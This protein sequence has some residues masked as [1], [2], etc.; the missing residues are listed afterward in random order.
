MNAVIPY[1]A[2]VITA[3]TSRQPWVGQGPEPLLNRCQ[4]L[5]ADDPL[6]AL[7]NWQSA[8]LD[9]ALHQFHAE[10]SAPP[11]TLNDTPP[12]LDWVLGDNMPVGSGPGTNYEGVVRNY[13]ATISGTLRVS[14]APSSA[15]EF[16]PGFHDRERHDLI[17]QKFEQTGLH[18]GGYSDNFSAAFRE[19][20]ARYRSEHLPAPIYESKGLRDTIEQAEEN[21]E[22]GWIQTIR[23]QMPHMPIY[24][25]SHA[26][27]FASAH[28]K[29][30]IFKS[31]NHDPRLYFRPHNRGAIS[32]DGI[33]RQYVSIL[34]HRLFNIDSIPLACFAQ[35]RSATLLQNLT[36][37]VQAE[38][39]SGIVMSEAHG[40][41]PASFSDPGL[42]PKSLMNIGAMAYLLRNVDMTPGNCIKRS[43][44][45]L[46]AYDWDFSFFLAA[47]CN[48]SPEYNDNHTHGFACQTPDD[49]SDLFVAGLIAATP[50]LLTNLLWPH[51]TS[52]ELHSL[53][54][55]RTVILTDIELRAG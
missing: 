49:Y 31:L 28:W 23:M 33:R 13:M 19:C 54:F 29:P 34:L 7:G 24:G 46:L 10:I 42:D 41:Q 52:F 20:L 55:R 9:T 8:G 45:R 17:E 12:Q 38:M 37:P 36:Q 51:L 32:V 39:Y 43:D 14:Q 18:W 16:P 6:A 44:G 25:L 47:L 3:L 1:S 48:A 53:L 27:D 5:L 2:R 4:T 40:R 15:Y 26:I 11:G 50:E 21:L 22:A 35:V 30:S